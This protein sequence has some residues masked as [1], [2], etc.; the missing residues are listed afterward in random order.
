MFSKKNGNIHFH[1]MLLPYL[2]VF[3]FTVSFVSYSLVSATFCMCMCIFV[4]CTCCQHH[5]QMKNE[6]KWYENKVSHWVRQ[7]IETFSMRI[8]SELLLISE[9]RQPEQKS[10]GIEQGRVCV[11]VC[12]MEKMGGRL[13]KHRRKTPRV[14]IST[15]P[16]ADGDELE[17]DIR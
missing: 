14:E 3:V 7:S 5:H 16:T 6:M 4:V 12:M 13:R 1:H 15:K 2:S 10:R 11:C 8:E 17:N 9:K